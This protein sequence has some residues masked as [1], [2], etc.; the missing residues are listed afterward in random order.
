MKDQFFLDLTKGV[1]LSQ[2]D[3]LLPQ[4]EKGLALYSGTYNV[5]Y[6]EEAKGLKNAYG[7]TLLGE[8]AGEPK[9]TGIHESISGNDKYLLVNTDEGVLYEM[10]LVD[11]S[12]TE[13]EDGFN[14][15]AQITYLNTDDGARQGTIV[16]DGVNDP[17]FVYKDGADWEIVALNTPSNARGSAMAEFKKRIF[18]GAGKT[19][20]WAA[21]GDF[22]DWTTADDA[23][24]SSS[25]AND[26][27]SITALIPYG[28]FLAIHKRN[29]IYS[30]IG[31]TN[32]D[33]W[34]FDS[35]SNTKG[36][37]S[38][39]GVVNFIKNQWLFDN[40]LYSLE[41]FNV[42]G[43]I[44][45]GGEYSE[46][47]NVD[48]VNFDEDATEK[49][50][51]IP[52]EKRKQ[53]RLYYQKTG[54]NNI[55]NCWIYDVKRKAWYPRI[56]NDEITCGTIF[57]EDIYLA[58]ADGKV[59]I[60]DFGLTFNDEPVVSRCIFP[61]LHFGNPSKKKEVMGIEFK[62]SSEQTQGFNIYQRYDNLSNESLT[63]VKEV[64]MSGNTSLWDDAEWDDAEWS[65]SGE[66]FAKYYPK[67]KH[68]SFQFALGC[69]ETTD[70][71]CLISVT[72]KNI[73]FSND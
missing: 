43:Q 2:S 29:K 28:N 69:N 1:I 61:F 66:F 59:L 15:D 34:Q 70:A 12:V 37:H 30:L 20:F 24:E 47:I 32:P 49:T 73:K 8:I 62:L 40:G 60:E 33:A 64:D 36:A 52:Y 65:E 42:L 58:T 13:I 9:I 3:D 44:H 25:F 57:A 54:D 27:E 21:L 35:L 4:S 51:I 10:S 19:I 23:G 6:Y 38:E 56:L 17:V 16:N 14:T 26:G 55:K 67:G 31:D 63:P 22:T 11:G 41:S 50:F 72:A 48:F 71:F 45:L 39:R 5:E 53:L 68:R 18:I 46:N 7:Y